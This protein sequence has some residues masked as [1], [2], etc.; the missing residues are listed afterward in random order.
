M[1]TPNSDGFKTHKQL[2]DALRDSS[3]KSELIKDLQD[4]VSACAKLVNSY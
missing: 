2:E 3:Q 4:K 1:I